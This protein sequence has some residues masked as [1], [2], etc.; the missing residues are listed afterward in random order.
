M[1]HLALKMACHLLSSDGCSNLP[2]SG[3]GLHACDAHA[4]TAAPSPSSAA[5]QTGHASPGA[6]GQQTSEESGPASLVDM[7][8]TVGGAASHDHEGDRPVERWGSGP[9]G[10]GSGPNVGLL[11]EGPEDEGFDIFRHS[12]E[13]LQHHLAQADPAGA[14]GGGSECESVGG[15][16]A[17]H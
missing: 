8:Q 15:G 5:L 16:A 11:A 12:S 3:V 7:L 2:D 17:S 4:A 14:G 13:K 1:H 6:G 10:R 9:Q